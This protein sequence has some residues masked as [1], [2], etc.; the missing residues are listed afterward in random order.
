M[1]NS[2]GGIIVFG[3]DDDGVD[4]LMFTDRVS[5]I[6]PAK[7]TD[8]VFKYTG[9]HFSDFALTFAKRPSGESRAALA[10]RPTLYP[11][12]F[13]QPGSY[14]DAFSKQKSAFAQGTLYFR[15]GAKSEVAS[16]GD[17]RSSFD[18]LLAMTRHEWLDGI[19]QVVETAPGEGVTVTR[20]AAKMDPGAIQSVRLTNDPN[21]PPISPS[22][23][24]SQYPFRGKELI[25]KLKSKL[26]SDVHFT[27]HTLVAIRYTHG[28]D[29]RVEYS[30]TP[31]F[32]SRLYSSDFMEWIIAA[33]RKDSSFFEY[34]VAQYG[35]RD[36]RPK[37]INTAERTLERSA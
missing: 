37:S 22:A 10:I 28:V 36:V 6:D 26:G 16:P 35:N 2:T 3:V 17:I 18:R 21:A 33:Y 20:G 19:R 13:T 7:I 34:A 9:I 1:A 4:C 25:L 29:E 15:H 5:A 14:T 32:G 12:V 27:S 24:A 11:M 23:L 8:K 30:H 31:P